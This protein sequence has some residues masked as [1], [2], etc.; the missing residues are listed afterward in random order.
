MRDFLVREEGR[1][2]GDE[3]RESGCASR[4]GF[5]QI[6]LIERPRRLAR[7]GCETMAAA[8]PPTPLATHDGSLWPP[9]SFRLRP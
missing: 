1:K 6:R 7:K 5:G 4:P 3:S 9:R 2:A 8:L